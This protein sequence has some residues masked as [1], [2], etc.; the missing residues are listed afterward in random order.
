MWLHVVITFLLEGDEWSPSRFDCFS[1]YY[2]KTTFLLWNDFREVGFEC[3]EFTEMTHG[4]V[5]YGHY[6]FVYLLFVAAVTCVFNTCEKFVGPLYR[7]ADKSL[8]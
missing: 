4:V 1:P 5:K 7:G 2:N 3:V 8:A 6:L